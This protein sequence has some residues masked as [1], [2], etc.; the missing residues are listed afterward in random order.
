MKTL[1]QFRLLDELRASDSQVRV[2]DLIGRTEENNVPKKVAFDNETVVLQNSD[3][4]IFELTFCSVANGIM[5]LH[6]RGLD[7][8]SPAVEKPRNRKTR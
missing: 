8:N 1:Y 4:S 6:R 5:T 3:G 7:E 2:S